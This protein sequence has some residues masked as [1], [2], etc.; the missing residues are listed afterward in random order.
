VAIAH[1][2]E[3]PRLVL[4]AGTGVRTL[5]AILEGQPFIGTIVLSHVHWDHVM[6]LPFFAAGD[7]PDAR[8]RVLLPAQ[9][10][11]EL[12]SDA[13]TL[14]ERM[15]SPPLFPIT[16]AQ[17]RG[18]WCFE[19]YDEGELELEG[20]TLLVR[21]IP[22]TGGRTMGVRV[23]AAGRS[24]AYMPDHAPHQLGLGERGSGEL[25]PAAREL[26]LDVDVLIHD[27][28]YTRHELQE[29]FTWGHAVADYPV[30]LAEVSGAGRVL[31]FHHDPS[32]TDAAVAALHTEVTTTTNVA[33]DVAVEGMIIDL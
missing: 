29:R 23:A 16:P 25:H 3:P 26:A 12:D 27:A 14:L 21:E 17:L 4:D 9:D 10:V 5:S 22:H 2:G 30:H 15:M 32:R 31:L 33:V 11:A 8:V 7:H 20:F 24:I 1:D 6:G 28:Q 18:Q 19:T 13:E